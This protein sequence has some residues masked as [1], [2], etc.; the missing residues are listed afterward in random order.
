MVVNPQSNKQLRGKIRTKGTLKLPLTISNIVA[1][2][3][4]NCPREAIID[5]VE[6]CLDVSN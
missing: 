3:V 1:Y 5:C 4:Y 2:Y 6:A